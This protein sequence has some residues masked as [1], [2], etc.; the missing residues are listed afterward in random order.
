MEQIGGDAERWKR[1]RM[2]LSKRMR[3]S[4][5]ADENESRRR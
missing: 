3:A 1:G 5:T 4:E 2:L